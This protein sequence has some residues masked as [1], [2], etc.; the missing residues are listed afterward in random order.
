MIDYAV[1]QALWWLFIFTLF[2]LFFVFGGRDFGACILMPWIGKN[3]AERRMILNSI[4]TTWEGNQVWFITAGGATFAAW[5]LVYATAFSGLYMA[6]FIVLL[7]L[8][9]RPPGF[10]FRGK[11]ANPTWRKGWDWALFMSGFVPALI[12]GVALGNLFV[13]L[14]FHLDANMQSFYEGSFWGLL[15]PLGLAFGVAAVLL[16]TLQGGLFLQ[17]KLP[18]P[19]ASRAAKCNRLISLLFLLVFVLI[20]AWMTLRSQGYVITHMPAK[21]TAFLPF[22]KTVAL[23]PFAWLQNYALWPALFV[24]PLMTCVMMLGVIV[25]AWCGCA[26]I[27]L[28]LNSVAIISALG[29]AGVSLFPFILPSSTHPSHSLT[30]WDATSSHLTL[31]YMFWAAVIFLPII[32]SYTFWVFRVFK[33]KIVQSEVINSPESY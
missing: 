31:N 4:G 21:G 19:V 3:D 8:I 5:P 12:F 25:C 18:E 22:A 9:S 32:F 30:V 15:N 27:G 11:M 10:D 20:G 14:P 26:G 17:H 1:L 13:G 7:S 6:L 2:A 33:G 24:L 28:L 23:V 16:L 29:T